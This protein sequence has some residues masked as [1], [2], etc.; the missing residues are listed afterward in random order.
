MVAYDGAQGCREEM[1]G[2]GVRVLYGDCS[3][4]RRHSTLNVVSMGYS[5]GRGCR[6]QSNRQ[7]EDR[8][9]R[10]GSARLQL[11]P[12]IARAAPAA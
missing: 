8:I 7:G 1:S 12:E 10:T 2:S 11:E 5:T 3:S 4:D 9:L 6:L